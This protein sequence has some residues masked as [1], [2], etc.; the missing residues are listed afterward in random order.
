MAFDNL[1]MEST[2]SKMTYR[3]RKWM[4]SNMA[5]NLDRHFRT[6]HYE[7]MAVTIQVCFSDIGMPENGLFLI[8]N[9][10]SPTK[11]EG[12]VLAGGVSSTSLSFLGQRVPTTNPNFTETDI[13]W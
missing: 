5:V 3:E 9:R 8:E 10:I 6:L 7:Y 2:K 13:L 11:I 4:G 12:V 1:K